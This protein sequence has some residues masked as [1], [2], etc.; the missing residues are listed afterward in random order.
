MSGR[1]RLCDDP[2]PTPDGN[3]CIGNAFQLDICNSQ[4]CSGSGS[5]SGTGNGTGSGTRNE[6]QYVNVR[7]EFI[8]NKTNRNIY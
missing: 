5:G 2:A 4:S 8:S 6:A 7:F 3:P 1:V